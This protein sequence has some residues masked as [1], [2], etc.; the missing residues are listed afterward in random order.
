MVLLLAD[1]GGVAVAVRHGLALQETLVFQ[2][3]DLRGDG[4]VG[5]LGV[6][7]FRDDVAD[8]HLACV[9]DDLHDLFFFGCQ[10]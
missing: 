4:V 7:E 3:F 10:F 5:G 9:P 6:G 1:D 8:E 2:E